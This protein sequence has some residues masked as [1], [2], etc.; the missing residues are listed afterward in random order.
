MMRHDIRLVGISK[1]LRISPNF[2]GLWINNKRES[3]KVKEYFLNV[4]KIPSYLIEVK[5]AK[6]RNGD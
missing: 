2:I 1:V 6:L 5:N 4:L 3:Q